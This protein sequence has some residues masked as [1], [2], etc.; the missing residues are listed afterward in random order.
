MVT[1]TLAKAESGAA[2]HYTLDGSEPTTLDPIYEVPLQLTEPTVVR[3]RAFKQ[4]FTRS[5]T[6]QQIYIPGG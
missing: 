4:G 3:A 2:I 6:A 5:I 1:V